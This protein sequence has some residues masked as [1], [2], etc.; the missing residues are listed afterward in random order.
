M[1]AV[2]LTKQTHSIVHSLKTKIV[3]NL[4][5][6]HFPSKHNKP[7]S[8]AHTHTHTHT[9]NPSTHFHPTPSPHYSSS[10]RNMAT[11]ATVHFASRPPLGT[12][13]STSN[14]SRDSE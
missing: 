11:P 1:L 7:Q 14:R 8:N 9:F 5:E 4:S 12:V 13:I 10:H 3:L 2:A 6:E